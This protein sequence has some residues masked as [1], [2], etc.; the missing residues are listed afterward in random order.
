MPASTV[1]EWIVL[2]INRVASGETFTREDFEAQPADGWDEIEPKRGFSRSDRVPAYF[3]W[4]ALRRWTSDDD[5]RA[6]DPEYG[7]MRMREMLGFLEQMEL[8]QPE[9][10]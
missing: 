5:I 7:P 6:K 8:G 4:L 2:S 1:R 10:R 9:M 3:A